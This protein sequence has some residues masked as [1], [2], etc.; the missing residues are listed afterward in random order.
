MSGP[1]PVRL[2]RPG[3]R[4]PERAHPG[5]AGLDLFAAEGAELAPGGRTPVPTGLAVAIPDGFAGLVV[6][7]SGLALRAGVTVA[8][9]PGLIDAGYRGELMVILVNLGSEPH[10]VEPGDRIAQL[11]LTPVSL[12]TA[13]DVDE[14]PPHDGRG[15]GGFGSTGR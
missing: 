2:I 14:L 4:L 13:D 11:V 12:A 8:N 6:P 7:R 10:R 5:D 9:A 1:L 15:E 3:A